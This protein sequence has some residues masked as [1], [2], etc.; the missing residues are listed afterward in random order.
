MIDRL[1][2]VCALASL[3]L[4]A[5]DWQPTPQDWAQ[6]GD[7]GT[8]AVLLLSRYELSGYQTQRTLRFHILQARGKTVIPQ[9]QSNGLPP[10]FKGSVFQPSGEVSHFSF[11]KDALIKNLDPYRRRTKLIVPGLT[12]NCIVEISYP[13]FGRNES[14]SETRYTSGYLLG[15]SCPTLLEEITVEKAYRFN[16]YLHSAGLKPEIDEDHGN[17]TI[18][19]RN[20]PPYLPIAFSRKATIPRP[21]FDLSLDPGTLWW[22]TRHRPEDFW[23]DVAGEAL[24]PAYFKE[25]IEGRAYRDL[26]ARLRDH[27][28]GSPIQKAVELLLR[29]Q[30]SLAYGDAMLDRERVANLAWESR[31]LH[32]PSNL[33]MLAEEKVGSPVGMTL[34]FIHV[35]KDAGIPFQLALGTDSEHFLFNPNERIIT[36]LTETLVRVEDSAGHF[37]FLDPA[38]RFLAPGVIPAGLQGM[39][40]L[41]VDPQTRTSTFFTWPVQSALI[42]TSRYA[43]R[44]HMEEGDFAVAMDA[45]FTGLADWEN[46]TPFISLDPEAQNRLL[47][48]SLKQK[49]SR[50]DIQAAEVDHA[51]SRRTPFSLHATA[52][53][54]SAGHHRTLWDPFPLMPSPLEIPEAWPPLR[55]APIF[56]PY[57]QTWVATSELSLP[58]G[59]TASLPPAF[60]HENAF[61][62]VTWVCQAKDDL[63]Q[64]VFRVD[65]TQSIATAAQYA[66]L[67]TF[68]G[69]MQEA[70]NRALILEG[71]Q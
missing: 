63:V 58:P 7:H 9:F 25:P 71:K 30:E 64:V 43:F 45:T 18:R 69:W 35:L 51:D 3:S 46:R 19:F 38:H 34:L 6:K 68:L 33:D 4:F 13:A 21:G 26:S 67:R 57:A 36:T 1:F 54:G 61:G 65:Q 17:R 2:L 55:T 49:G 59:L 52:L 5:A 62:K 8:G 29:I 31:T 23:K 22:T 24:L 40:G 53:I 39:Q 37:L 70:Q 15:A 11:T 60:I 56:L 66:E 44:T 50:P 42:N 10:W 12:E 48:D 28:D 32:Q 14:E 20:L 47:K 27:L 41:L 16:F